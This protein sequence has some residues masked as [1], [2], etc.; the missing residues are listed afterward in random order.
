MHEYQKG[1]FAKDEQ[2]V[3]RK[4]NNDQPRVRPLQHFEHAVLMSVSNLG[5]LAFPAEI[6]RRLSRLLERHVSLAQVFVSLERM[7]DRGLISSQ[8]SEPEHVR[9]GRRRRIFRL[10]ASG[11]HMLSQTAAAYRRMSSE[12]V[13]SKENPNAT[14]ETFVPSAT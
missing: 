13:S 10:E 14:D 8:E 7:E 1:S 2:G 3:L 9:G 6:A 4:V 11:V 12:L 5:H